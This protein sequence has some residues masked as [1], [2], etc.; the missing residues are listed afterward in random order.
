[1]VELAYV[2]L[3]LAVAGFAKGVV[4]LGL[5]P[6][7]M[8]F[9]VL[10]VPPVEAAAIMVLPALLTNA[11]QAAAG[12]ALRDLLR[13]F[14][15]M[16]VLT[17]LATLATAPVLQRSGDVATGVLGA[18][19]VVYAAYSLHRP[20]ASISATVERRVGPLCGIATGVVTGFTGVSSMPSVPFLQSTGLHRDDFV[21][22]IG[23]SFT[24]S[25]LAL[26]AGLGLSGGLASVT[27]SA[28]GLATAGAFA[29]MALGALLRKRL[30]EGLFRRLFLWALVL[31][32]TYLLVKSMVFARSV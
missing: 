32:G 3:V 30:P 5:P 31:L 15:L 23:L 6:I 13:R 26:A 1:M 9:L 12:P 25:A 19:L 20:H 2:M 24:V 8:G 16:L 17:G 10:T 14:W 22:A 29:G 28:I 11:W 7:A 18:L 21:Q 4:G 27:P